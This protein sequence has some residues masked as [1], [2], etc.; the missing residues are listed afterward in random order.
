MANNGLLS[1]AMKRK[2]SVFG[3][4]YL[5]PQGSFGEF[6]KKFLDLQKVQEII[7]KHH[8]P[9][10]NCFEWHFVMQYCPVANYHYVHNLWQSVRGDSEHF[11][12]FVISWKWKHFG[13]NCYQ[14]INSSYN[15]IKFCINKKYILIFIFAMY[16]NYLKLS[17]S[18]HALYQ[19]YLKLSISVHAL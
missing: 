2:S 14:G 18:V 17:I 19:N 5:K 7:R 16:Q 6:Y 8:R 15:S 11:Y 3:K 4:L 1:M 9:S 12:V 13:A 10:C